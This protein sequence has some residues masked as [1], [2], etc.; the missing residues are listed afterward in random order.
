MQ[1]QICRHKWHT[2]VRIR[3]V[4]TLAP[5]HKQTRPILQLGQIPCLCVHEAT[6]RQDSLRQ[7]PTARQER[8]LRPMKTTNKF[9]IS[10]CVN[11]ILVISLLYIA[12]VDKH[13][14]IPSVEGYQHTIDSLQVLI[15]DNNKKLDS[16]SNLE[17]NGEK[18][19]SD[20]K[21]QLTTLSQKNK[22]LK[23]KYD[24]EVALINSMSDDDI[25]DLFSETF[26]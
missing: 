26:K 8:K 25:V 2:H 21:N 5:F 13:E 15:V 3:L 17:K 24:E 9:I 6:S 14:K 16:L 20:L 22:N 23:K 12:L 4:V 11:I 10:I 7:F 19:I 1:Q 18:N